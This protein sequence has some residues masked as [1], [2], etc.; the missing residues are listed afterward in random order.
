MT[1]QD[2]LEML[3]E[4]Y[5]SAFLNKKEVAKELHISAGTVDRLR[6]EGQLKSRK[7]VGQVFFDI[8]EVARFMAEA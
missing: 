3:K 8:G 4:H 1:Q 5:K 7:V 2:F 6:K